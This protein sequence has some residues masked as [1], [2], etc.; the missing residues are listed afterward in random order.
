MTV[1]KGEFGFLQ[2]MEVE[3]TPILLVRGGYWTFPKFCN[4][5]PPGW[6]VDIGAVSKAERKGYCQRL[7]SLPDGCL[8]ARELTVK[9]RI[10]ALRQLIAE[11][12][13]RRSPPGK[14]A[15]P[16]TRGGAVRDSEQVPTSGSNRRPGARPLDDFARGLLKRVRDQLREEPNSYTRFFRVI[17]IPEWKRRALPERYPDDGIVA[18]PAGWVCI[19]GGTESPARLSAMS[20]QEL[21]GACAKILNLTSEEV[22]GLFD[23]AYWPDRHFQKHSHA[24]SLRERARAAVIRIE[25]A[26]VNGI[27]TN[28]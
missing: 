3:Q 6:Y 14:N 2:Y 9:G 7:A 17:V 1:P 16:K 10:Y 12:E 24:K 26:I 4:T 21:E 27:H 5:S 8:D 19:L 11:I 18:C 20:P 25:D 22:R 15:I 28:D 23:Y 13:K